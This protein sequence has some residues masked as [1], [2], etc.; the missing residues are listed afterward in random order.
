MSA[1]MLRDKAGRFSRDKSLLNL[2]QVRDGNDVEPEVIQIRVIKPARI[3]E[4][5]NKNES[6]EE[7]NLENSNDREDDESKIMRLRIEE[8]LH[9][10]TAT[11]KETF[12]KQ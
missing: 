5:V 9:T 1:Q 8:V 12:V 7:E 10:L 2:I 11:M 4:N 6:N 3:E